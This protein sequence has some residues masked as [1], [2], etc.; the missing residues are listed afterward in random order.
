LTVVENRCNIK[1]IETTPQMTNL[2]T[3]EDWKNDHKDFPYNEETKAD[4]KDQFAID[5][6][7]Y[8]TETVRVYNKGGYLEILNNGTFSVGIERDIFESERIEPIERELYEWFDGQFFNV[9][10]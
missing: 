4:L 8:R 10:G 3:F 6:V 5:S 9:E 2:I 7:D 1:G